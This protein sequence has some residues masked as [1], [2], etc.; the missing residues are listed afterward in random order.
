MKSSTLATLLF[1]AGGFVLLTS[2]EHER[3]RVRSIA[4]LGLGLVEL[5]AD[6]GG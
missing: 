2:R 4:A 3:R 1:L 5:L 6:D